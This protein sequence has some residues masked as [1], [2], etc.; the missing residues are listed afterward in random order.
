LV[1]QF[2]KVLFRN[3][4]G[5][6]FIFPENAKFEN[7]DLVIIPA[8][9]IASDELLNKISSYVEN[10]GHVIMQFKSGFCN[11]NSM[12]RPMLA[13][14]PLRKAC[15]FYYQ[16]FTN[17]KELSLKNNPFK[18]DEASN[19][20]YDWGEYLIPETAKPLAWYDHQYFGK[21]PAITINNF[22][23]GTLLYEGCGVSDVIQEKLILQEIERAGIQT[24]DQNL[25]WPLITKSGINDAGK[26]IHYYYNYSSQKSSIKYLHQAGNELVSGKA[27]TAGSNLEIGPWDVLI[28]KEN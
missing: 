3:N 19:K 4:V 25:H 22:G 8:L 9:Y 18:V 7:Y 20:V 24:V 26:R 10:G 6:D 13:P 12:V 21:Y 5:I 17:F 16:E 27:V 2:H 1:G 23:K 11:E 15:G 14:G 28:V